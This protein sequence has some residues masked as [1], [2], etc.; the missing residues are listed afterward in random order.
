MELVRNSNNARLRYSG[1]VNENG[2]CV[3][4][5]T[6]GVSR[7]DV[8]RNQNGKV[9]PCIRES[10]VQ[11][12][13]DVIPLDRIAAFLRSPKVVAVNE[14]KNSPYIVSFAG[15]RIMAGAGDKVYVRAI[16]NKDTPSYTVYRAGNPYVSPETGEILGYEAEHIADAALQEVGDPATLIIEKTKREILT[17]DRVM[18]Q[19]SEGVTL[20][21]FPQPPKQTVQGNIISIMGGVNQIGKYDVVVIDKG[22]RDGLIVGH[23]LT[24]SQRGKMVRDDYSGIN[25]NMIKM[26]D[27]I[28][29]TL[30]V[31]RPFEKVSYALV[32]KATLPIHVLDKVSSP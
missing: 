16:A 27:E 19:S 11:K 4:D 28:A 14:L 22:Q 26:P 24:I 32:M 12:A 2:T 9:F 21:Y 17:G 20:S 5:E 8:N 6:D 29:G 18:P 7:I 23:E 10:D 15:D 31:F 1:T 25:E 3:F 30:M 13:I